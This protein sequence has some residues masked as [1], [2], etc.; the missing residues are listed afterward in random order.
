M[1]WYLSIRE[2]AALALPT[3]AEE[4]VLMLLKAYFD[5][6]GSHSDSDVVV[7]GGLIG[8][9]PQW[10][11]FETAWMEKLQCP[12]P[13]KPALKKFGL[14]DCTNHVKDFLGWSDAESDALTHDFRRIILEAKLT[15]TA[16]AVDRNAWRNLVTGNYRKILGSDIG[17]CFNNCLA[18]V[19]T[20]AQGLPDGPTK[21]AVVIDQGIESA[22]M[23]EIAEVYMRHV[24]G[25]PWFTTITF[26]RV[27]QIQPLQGADT[28][29]TE[30]YWFA[31]AWLK[32]G[33]DAKPRAHMQ[34]YLKSMLAEGL[35]LDREA[36]VTE[37]S[38]RGP[39]GRLRES[40]A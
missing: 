27:D 22:A 35:I 38:L 3:G 23:R 8:T 37:L 2:L 11:A 21:I 30:S 32:F 39:D 7:I 31:R 10:T 1:D 20:F 15:S 36:I 33:L 12:L 5:D 19:M 26:G 25:D 14:A 28:V 6:A 34:H 17:A 18:R 40:P 16:S 4:G 29:A 9:I 24:G 13:S